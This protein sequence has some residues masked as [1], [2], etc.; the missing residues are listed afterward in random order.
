MTPETTEADA[1]FACAEPSCFKK[2]IN[3]FVVASGDG[4]EGVLRDFA[5][6]IAY[7]KTLR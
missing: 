4:Q 7:E 1:T 6:R 3:R 2:G 5:V